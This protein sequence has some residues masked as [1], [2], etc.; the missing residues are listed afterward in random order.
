M[1][2]HSLMFLAQIIL[3][4]INIYFFELIFFFIHFLNRG[5][6]S[7]TFFFIVFWH[8][9]APSPP[10]ICCPEQMPLTPSLKSG[11]D[12][13]ID[14]YKYIINIILCV[15]HNM[16]YKKYSIWNFVYIL[17]Y[18]VK[19]VFTMWL[20]QIEPFSLLPSKLLKLQLDWL[21]TF[22]LMIII[23]ICFTVLHY[24]PDK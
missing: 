9:D 18:Q 14:V 7:L 2:C 20:W 4:Q 19:Y 21:M 17:W 11:P 6:K 8:P 10:N 13:L 3:I 16:F 22:K 23:L 5:S 24:Y 12:Y 15:L 1:P